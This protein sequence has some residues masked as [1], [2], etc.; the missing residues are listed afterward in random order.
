[1]LIGSTIKDSRKVYQEGCCIAE[2]GVVDSW[3]KSLGIASNSIVRWPVSGKYVGHN[4]IIYYDP[5]ATVWKAYSKQTEVGLTGHSKDPQ[6]FMIR[7]I[8]VNY[9]F[10]SYYSTTVDLTEIKSMFVAN[11]INS[12]QM[13]GWV[14]Q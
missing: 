13:S 6:E 5:R 12:E 3:L 11:G 1:M 8:P 2:V 10:D 14:F 4:H 7:K 9:V